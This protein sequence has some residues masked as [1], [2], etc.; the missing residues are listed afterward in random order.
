MTTVSASLALRHAAKALATEPRAAVSCS[1][2]DGSVALGWA[3]GVAFGVAAWPTCG[4]A[5]GDGFGSAVCSGGTAQDA[6][7][8]IAGAIGAAPIPDTTI[9]V[10]TA[11]EHR[12]FFTV[13]TT[14]TFPAFGH[15]H[16][17]VLLRGNARVPKV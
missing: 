4:L 15:T 10:A 17:D 2:P 16:Q 6:G 7:A 5:V 12:K 9:A 3:M 11:S 14:S 13:I 8:A 1:D